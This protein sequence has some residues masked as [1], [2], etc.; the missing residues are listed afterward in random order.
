MN[1]LCFLIAGTSSSYL[2]ISKKML[3][4]HYEKCDVDFAHTGEECIRK[5][6]QTLYDV[7]LFDYELGDI[8][9]FEVI[10]S[11]RKRDIKTPLVLLVEEGQEQIAAKG[12]EKGASDYIVKLRGYLTALPF[13]IRNILER[14]HI[15]KPEPARLPQFEA[16]PEADQV[17]GHFILDRRGRILS[18]SQNME[19]ITSYS[20]A[21]LIELNL[22]DLIPKDKEKPFCEWLNILNENG[23][24]TESFHTEILGKTGA[25]VAIDL[26]LTPIR[27][28]N[29]NIVSYRGRLANNP[30]PV[31]I[32]PIRESQFNQVKM[33][34]QVWEL[35]TSSY[36][37]PLAVYLERVAELAARTFQ[38]QRCTLALLD[39]RKKA[40]V[41]QAMI[42][43]TVQLPVDS[44][45]MEVPQEVIDR[46]FSGRFRVKVIYYNQDK[47]D[48]T[49]YVSSGFVERRTQRRRPHGEWHKRDLV[50]LN[51]MNRGGSTFGYLSLDVPVNR[52]LPNRETFYNLEVFGQLIS[53][54]LESYHQISSSEK[55]SRRLKQMLVTSNIF[56]LN[57]SLHELLREVVWT[58]KFTLDFNLVALGLV[59]NR[60]GALE[61]KAVA[62]DDKFKLNQLCQ[63][64]FSLTSLAGLFRKEYSRG[65]SYFV[66]KEEEVLQPLKKIY[67][68]R[69]IERAQNAGWPKWGVILVP[70]KS[71][72]GKVVG[73]FLVDDPDNNRI[74]TKE[75]FRML[76]ILANQ[77]G[78]AIDNRI[79]YVQAKKRAQE[80]ENSQTTTS[81]IL[82]DY[83]ASGFKR[84]VNRLFG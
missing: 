68:G 83:T 58:A 3:K 45:Q 29:Q 41:K 16:L 28:E 27:D 24:S 55:R 84:L 82:P 72:D 62:C 51:L 8:T 12:L 23:N 44:Q 57:L 40:F 76:E 10:E 33:V 63:L 5:A 9:G 42:G 6:S 26:R 60:S 74:P 32:A 78:I 17:E 54:A 11:L 69:E 77:V 43:Y 52:N 64:N 49:S 39:K 38:F 36:Y 7:V 19:S 67:Y 71:R 81:E 1:N 65:K 31:S 48:T 21:E 2:E 73:A 59:S 30:L 75:V 79:L 20:E 37:E 4:F 70:V 50:L 34:H 47:L 35:L 13:T 25:K 61:I 80:L 14:H 53:M 66:V 56:K 18:A 15:L 46:I 22:L